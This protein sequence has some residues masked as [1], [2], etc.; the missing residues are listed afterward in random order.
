VT[1]LVVAERDGSVARLTLNRPDQR[2]AVSVAMIEELTAALDDLAASAD[3]RVVIIAGAGPDFCAGA[4]FAELAGSRS[5]QSG[6]DYARSFERALTAIAA[7]PSPVIAQVHGAALGAGCQIA[8]ACDLAVVAEDARLGIPSARLGILINLENIQRLVVAVGPK[9]AAE[10]LFTGRAMSGVEAADWGL[11]NATVP[12]ADLAG[13]TRDLAAS[14]TESAPLSVRGSKRG[15]ALV[16]SQ[17]SIAR[18]TN[19]DQVAGF[20]AMAA[21]ALAS[22]DLQEG[23][24]AFRDRRKPG[25]EG[26]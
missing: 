15:I 13:R 26:R 19:S 7:H 9:R 12:A 25:F 18:S 24:R 17:L 4:D 20:D 14:I 1:Q 16:L 2:N 22:E 8:V 23:I 5:G 10:I 21:A 6:I 3:V 11:A